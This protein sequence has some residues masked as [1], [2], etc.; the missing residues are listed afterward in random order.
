MLGSRS[1]VQFNLMQFFGVFVWHTHGM[2]E[3]RYPTVKAWLKC[4]LI[5]RLNILTDNRQLVLRRSSDSIKTPGRFLIFTSASRQ[6]VRPSTVTSLVPGASGVR[7]P[8]RRALAQGHAWCQRA[9]STAT[10][11]LPRIRQRLRRCAGLGQDQQTVVKALPSASRTARHR[12]RTAASVQLIACPTALNV[13]SGCGCG[14][15]SSGSEMGK[16]H[17]SGC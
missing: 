15:P 2:P 16:R 1:G 12:V 9:A 8:G 13:R 6:P 17:L 4:G 5:A 14:E 10:T 11:R 3:G 7:G